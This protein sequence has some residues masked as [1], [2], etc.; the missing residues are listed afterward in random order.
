MLASERMTDNPD[1]RSPEITSAR[2]RASTGATPS[3]GSSSSSSF[4]PAISALPSETSFC[5]PP[6]NC[7]AFASDEPCEFPS[8]DIQ[9]D[10]AQDGYWTDGH[11]Y[12]VKP[13]HA[14]PPRQ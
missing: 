9:I 10:V 11:R 7:D 4:R 1:L 6:D 2:R 12:A 14:A 8:V 5:W 3:N 13:Q